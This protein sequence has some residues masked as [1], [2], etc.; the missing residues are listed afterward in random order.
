VWLTAWCPWHVYLLLSFFLSTSWINATMTNVSCTLQL[1]AWSGATLKIP[2]MYLRKCF[3]LLFM[4]I[5]FS[6]CLDS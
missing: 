1:Q 4:N 3:L 2:S 6:K 5:D